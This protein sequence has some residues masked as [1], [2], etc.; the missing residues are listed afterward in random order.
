MAHDD[1]VKAA[2]RIVCRTLW[3]AFRWP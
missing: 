2:S 1:T 3:T